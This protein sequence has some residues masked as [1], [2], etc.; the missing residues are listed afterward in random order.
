MNCTVLSAAIFFMLNLE[1][2]VRTSDS[3]IPVDSLINQQ[4]DLQNKDGRNF[5]TNFFIL[6]LI[7]HMILLFPVARIHTVAQ[8]FGHVTL[9]VV[10]T[11]IFQLYIFTSA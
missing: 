10:V 11:I 4:C 8:S 5:L 1:L 3:P 2:S 6:P 9:T 7:P